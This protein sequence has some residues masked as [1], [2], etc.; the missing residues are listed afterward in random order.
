[1]FDVSVEA[2]SATTS[3]MPVATP[4]HLP[5]VGDFSFYQC[6]TE[7]TG[8]RALTGAFLG[9]SSMTVETC[10]TFCSSYDF[11]GLEYAQECFCG[12]SFS[13]GSVAAPIT[14]CNMLCLGDS[15]QYCGAG[16][17][18]SVYAR[19]GTSIPSG[20]QTTLSSTTTSSVPVPTGFP[21]GW[22]DRGCWVDGANGRIL[23]YQAPDD[24]N[25]TL[26]SCVATCVGLGYAVAGAEY[27][28]QC[29]CGNYIGNGG[30]LATDQAT[31]NTPCDGDSSQMCGGPMRMTIYSNA[32]LESLGP[33]APQTTGLNGTWEYVGCAVDNLNN[34]RTFPWQLYF[35]GTLDANQCLDKCAEFGY[36]AGGLEYGEECYCGDPRDFYDSGSSFV[37]DS[38][39]NIVCAGN[40]KHICGGGSR[41]T[42]YF[43]SGDPLYEFSYPQTPDEAGTYEFL[44]GGVVIPLLTMQSIT[45][46]VT[47]LEKAGTGPPNS[48]G[49]YELDLAAIDNFALAW[50]EMHVRTDI[51]CS[52]GVILPDVAGRQLNVGGWSGESTEGV[53]L[54]IPD[55]SP[56]VQGPNDWEEDVDV[57]KL[58]DGRWYPTAM[59]M[60]NGSILIVG[61]EEG[62][63]GAAVPTLEILPYTG[64]PP[65]Y[66]DWLER[67]DPNNLYPFLFVLPSG[68]IFVSYWNEARILDENTFATIRTLPDIPAA[69][70]DRYGGRTYPLEGT[71]VLLP[72]HAPYT[73][74]LGVL[75]CGGSTEGV[76]NALDNCVSIE[77]DAA[78]P[79][80]ILERMPSPRVMPCM[81]PL[82]DGTYMIMNGAK[83][84]VAGFGLATD[85]NLNALLYDPKKPVGK[86]ITVMANTTVPRLYHS[87]SITLLDGRV[88]VS[89]SDPQD[90]V[91]NQEYRVEVFVPPYLHKG[92]PRPTFTLADI[93]WAYGETVSFTIGSAAQNGAIEVSLL[94]SV[95]STHGN[96]MGSRTIFP[97]V[98]C[99]GTSCTVVAP[100]NAYVCPPGWYQFFV[101]DGGIPAVGVYVRIG[102]DP[103]F[104]GEWPQGEQFTRPGMEFPA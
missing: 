100:P 51:F 15:S 25:M 81:A 66:M 55:G 92:L 64:T 6:M 38:E 4:S 101:L 78:E 94:G 65:L 28:R 90:G 68:G 75:I 86:R 7:G 93:D 72:Q 103:A 67:T 79:E 80:W 96:S 18:L 27:H 44:I 50:K 37:D 16:N 53:R 36:M 9:G 24:P 47:F 87:E 5:A 32:D 40:P 70:N 63:N 54:Y 13:T 45:G 46:K 3:D 10:A 98:S 91:H 73:D 43:W 11:F 21:E 1:M 71:A 74:N 83:H 61:G 29:F 22:E 76:S 12:N 95:S 82:P 23:Q 26:Q 57:L 14:D 104:L 84:G 34:Q 69:I 56:R 20:T 59:T 62:S 30:V 19:N 35:P 49:A 99:S 8:V 97:Q 48:T 42:T 58:Q 33:P 88:L 52:A 41:I 31:C 2:S 17:R 60:A 85:P 89:G 39:C 77:P 102:G